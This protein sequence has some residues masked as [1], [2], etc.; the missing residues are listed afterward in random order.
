MRRNTPASPEPNSSGLI[1]PLEL[2]PWDVM[3]KICDQLRLL[4]PDEDFDVEFRRTK[5]KD[6][7]GKT[8]NTRT[9]ETSPDFG[10]EAENGNNA[11]NYK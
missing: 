7:Q 5:R 9:N 6:M 8:S 11:N 1:M 4:Q 2:T 10:E 3:K